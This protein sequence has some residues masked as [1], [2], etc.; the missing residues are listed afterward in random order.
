MTRNTSMLAGLAA[1]AL[2]TMSTGSAEATDYTISVWSGG[3][4]PND[5]YRIDAI[6]I[7]AGLLEAEYSVR[8]E[9]VNITIEGKPYDGWEEFKQSVTLAAEAGTSPHIVV[10]GHEDIAAWAQSGLVVPIEDYVDLDSWPIN[11]IY[12]NLI[13]ISSFNG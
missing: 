6:K 10:A 8:G 3:S 1:A 13:A 12:D 7:A 11:D 5:N 4:G 9:D 2:L